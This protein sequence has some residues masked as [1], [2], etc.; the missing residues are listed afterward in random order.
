MN[1][2]DI[3]L[4][5]IPVAFAAGAFTSLSVRADWFDPPGKP[6]EAANE[7]VAR[8]PHEAFAQA[9]ARRR[10]AESNA[11]AHQMLAVSRQPDDP[12]AR[13]AAEAAW[14]SRAHN[15]DF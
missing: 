13:R 2:T 5:C 6:L 12:G 8:E 3:L 9:W 1:P 15:V 4:L 11:V 7:P 10:E 14:Q